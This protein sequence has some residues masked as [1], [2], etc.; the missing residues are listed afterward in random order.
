MGLKTQSQFLQSLKDGRNVWYDGKKVDDV[1]T[2]PILSIFVNH[3]S[4]VY[5]AQEDPNVRNIFVKKDPK[6]GDMSMFYNIPRGTED[7]LA[8]RRVIETTTAYC[9][10]QFNI[11]KAIGTDAMFAMMSTCSQIDKK[12]ETKYYDNVMKLYDRCVREDLGHAVAQTDVKG[13]RGLRPHE[14]ADPDMYVHIVDRKS[15]GIVVRG[16]KVHTTG[17]QAV[18]EIIA[19]PT[20]SLLPEEKDYAVAFSIPANDKNVKMISRPSAP[21]EWGEFDYPL[22]TTAVAQETL[23]VFDNVFI[24]NERIFMA[25]EVEFAGDLAKLFALWHRFTAISY[26]PP[27]GDQLV[28][29]AQLIAEYNGVDKA[30]H[31]RNKIVKLIQYVEMIRACSKAAAMDYKKMP[32][33]I[34]APNPVFVYIGKFHMANNFHEAAKTLQDVAGGLTVTQPTF[35]DLENPETQKY[36]EKYLAGKKGVPTRDRLKL[37]NFI[38]DLTASTYSGG[39]NYVLSVHGEGSLEAQIIGTYTDYDIKRCVDYVKQLLKF[40]S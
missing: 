26:K 23:T 21:K 38:R 7:L 20:R 1:T 5:K 28:G 16:A 27:I 33:D 15:D 19:I 25:G 39:Y 29:A 22:S 31:I 40:N 6:Y 32:M 18:H 3:W 8:R 11:V 17:P 9:N 4:L 13:D 2:H 10:G 30:P 12:H 36:I 35:R 37:F 24:P 34:A 14:Q